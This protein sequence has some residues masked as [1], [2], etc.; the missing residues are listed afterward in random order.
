LRWATHRD[1]MRG[2]LDAPDAI[3]AFERAQ[4]A[5]S[6]ADVV[7]AIDAYGSALPREAIPPELVD[8]DVW[9]AL[10]RHGM[11]MTALV[12]NVATMTRLGVLTP[13]APETRTII[14]Q[15]ADTDRVSRSRI[16]PVQ[17]LAA[18]L[19]YQSGRSVRGSA[20][21]TP[22]PQI[23]DALDRLF[24]LAFGNVDATGTRW[25]IGLDVSGSMTGPNLAGVPGL[26]PRVA[27]AAMAMTVAASGDPY[28]VVAFTSAGW[29]PRTPD[30]YQRPAG[31][32]PCGGVT[33]FPL[34]ARQRL[35]D[36]CANTNRLD[37]GGTDC[38]LPMLYAL[39]RGRDVD[40]FVILTDSE[41]WAGDVHPTQALERY[42]QRTG[43]PARLAVVG[44]T[45]NGFSIADSRDPRQADFV[46]F[47]TSVPQALSE[48]A[49]I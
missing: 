5:Q 10:L 3:E 19:T 34:S 22:V 24:Y 40:C 20:T 37:F 9:R 12:R 21:W 42:R 16:H 36:V 8:A 32:W 7:A 49:R 35:D 13:T 15:L 25:L 14:E 30:P 4:R 31:F 2:A 38:A 45:S 26:S 44:M 6:P 39:E 46:G 43:I 29:A 47:D 11:P 23:V 17:A 41:T 27:A 18:L 33:P 48:F 28:E 1:E